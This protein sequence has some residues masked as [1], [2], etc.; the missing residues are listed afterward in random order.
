MADSVVVAGDRAVQRHDPVE[1]RLM[2]G[3]SSG[4]VLRTSRSA[5]AGGV[6]Q[7]GDD[8]AAGGVELGA[9]RV[10]RAQGR[11]RADGGD[12]AVDHGDAAAGDDRPVGRHGDDVGVDDQQV[13]RAGVG[14]ARRGSMVMA[15]R[16]S[17]R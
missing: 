14:G 13:G 15:G 6:D 5:G 17:C 1:D 9:A 3:T 7:A 8:E 2:G 16:G 10:R 11:R 12:P 4:M